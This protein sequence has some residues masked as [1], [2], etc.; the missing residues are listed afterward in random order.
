V[1]ES[2]WIK[3]NQAF[4]KKNFCINPQIES[5]RFGLTNPDSRVHK[6]GLVRIWD[7]LIRNFK[8]LFCTIVLKICEDSWGF[9]RFVKTGHIFWKLAGLVVHDSKRIF[10]SQDSWSTIQT[11]SVFVVYE[12]IQ[13]H[14][15]TIPATLLKTIP[16]K[17][18]I[19]LFHIFVYQTSQAYYSAKIHN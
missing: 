7:S 12:L 19:S 15:Y 10:S 17:S 5:L 18:G 1:D 3:T 4:L 13:I 6:S 8:D 2:L 9:V 11:K 14:G 16:I